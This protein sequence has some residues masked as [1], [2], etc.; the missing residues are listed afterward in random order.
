MDLFMLVNG[1]SYFGYVSYFVL[2]YYI[3]NYNIGTKRTIFTGVIYFLA[4][5]LISVPVLAILIFAV[6]VGII[7]VLIV[8]SIAGILMLTDCHCIRNI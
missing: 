5:G 4:G 3:T 8:T 7:K 6:F 1:I 2:G